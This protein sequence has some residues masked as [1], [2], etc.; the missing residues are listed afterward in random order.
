MVTCKEPLR[1]SIG[2][3]LRALLQASV[4][5]SQRGLVEH[6]VQAVCT[7]NLDLACTFIERTTTDKAISLT[8]EALAAALEARIKHREV[9]KY[10]DPSKTVR[11][12][13][14]PASN[15]V[16]S[17]ILMSTSFLAVILPH[18]PRHFNPN[19]AA[20]R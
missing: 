2:N 11:S 8:D 19:Q 4:S 16:A 7:D 5:E 15:P 10:Q 3:H 6:A 20:S 12:Y 17:P 13:N 14:F 9:R 18:Y 1:V